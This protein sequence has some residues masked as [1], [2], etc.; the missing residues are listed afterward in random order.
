M[1][2]IELLLIG[3]SLCF[4]TFAVS[5]T[6]GICMRVKP[7]VWQTVKIFVT[8]ALFQAGLTF[9]GWALGIG[10]HSYIEKVDHWVAFIL[11]A[12]IGGNMLIEGLKGKENDENPCQ[13]C[14]KSKTN[15]LD[16]KNLCV[17]AVATSIDALAVGVSLAM[18]S[19]SILKVLVGLVSIFFFTALA[20]F[21][22]LKGGNKM[23]DRLG[24]KPE[25]VGGAILLAIGVKILI[26]HLAF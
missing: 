26:E 9:V 15:L 6:G 16:T 24:S 12:Y 7:T 22:G 5:L 11:L 1:S 21:V 14:K 8:F 20:S 13:E 17:L 23:G 4:D 2:Y 18:V 19:L 3:V 25:L 10:F